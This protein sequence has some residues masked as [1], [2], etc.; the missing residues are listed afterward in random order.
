MLMKVEDKMR[1]VATFKN[2][3]KVEHHSAALSGNESGSDEPDTI[4]GVPQIAAND[5]K[6][7]SRLAE[8][9]SI[10][11]KAVVQNFRSNV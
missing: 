1:Q 3:T 2:K 4:A 10:K 6:T 8:D 9:Q 11:S 7:T 5:K